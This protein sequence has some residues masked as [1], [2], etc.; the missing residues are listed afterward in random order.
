[1]SIAL[2][3]F[4][5]HGTS[6]NVEHEADGTAAGD[7]GPLPADLVLVKHGRGWPDDRPKP[8][9]DTLRLHG[10][11]AAGRGMSPADAAVR[12]TAEMKWRLCDPKELGFISHYAESVKEARK[13]NEAIVILYR[14]GLRTCMTHSH[15]ADRVLAGDRR[16]VLPQ[17]RRRRGRDRHRH[18]GRKYG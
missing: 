7:A 13:L 16:Y 10:C 5:G 17:R 9:R 11:A 1:M 14:T 8:T 15:E 3:H 6:A 2:K 18:P 12:V 4:D